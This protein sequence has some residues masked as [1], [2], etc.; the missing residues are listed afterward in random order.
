MGPLVT[1]L[2]ILIFQAGCARMPSTWFAAIRNEPAPQA[3]ENHQPRLQLK[4]D[5]GSTITPEFDVQGLSEGETVMVLRGADANCSS[6][7]IVG[8][9]VAKA[10]AL[11][12]R[13]RTL[14]PGASGTTAEFRA[15]VRRADGTVFCSEAVTVNLPAGT[16]PASTPYFIQLPLPAKQVVY[17]NSNEGCALAE[18][19]T[20]WCWGNNIFGQ[21]GNGQVGG[22]APITQPSQV[23]GLSDVVQITNPYE[24]SYAALTKDGDIFWWGKQHGG[25]SSPQYNTPVLLGRY[26]DVIQIEKGFKLAADGTVS[27][28]HLGNPGYPDAL[29]AT[30]TS[31]LYTLDQNL[32]CTRRQDG[33]TACFDSNWPTGSQTELRVLPEIAHSIDFSLGYSF[34]CALT[35]VSGGAREI[36]CWNNQSQ[37]SP[38]QWYPNASVTPQALP[39]VGAKRL[40][41]SFYHLYWISEDSQVYQLG[42]S[43][44]SNPTAIPD[45]VQAVELYSN[46][47]H[48]FCALQEAGTVLCRRDT[49]F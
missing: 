33:S 46:S 19:G 3:P 28:I 39:I 20:V 6:G 29:V 21:L 35:Q 43:S 37:L 23:L 44:P 48:G 16:L 31:E 36:L 18:T 14:N 49:S 27:P 26:S 11:I 47:F 38:D 15:K 40:S 8:S 30:Q 45:F 42:L 5:P 22:S 41:Q 24:V 2:S 1:F 17:R 34:N 13:I 9:R 12:P 10:S 32:W 7:S 4:S 25:G